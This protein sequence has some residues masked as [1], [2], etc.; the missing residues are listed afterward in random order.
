[1]GRCPSCIWGAII[2]AGV[3]Y[4]SQVVTNYV[5]GKTGSDAW[6][7]VD[8]GK[9]VISAGVG[10]VTGGI[11]GLKAIGTTA[12]VYKAI[13]AS[14]TV[15]MGE[16][17]QQGY[18]NGT[19]KPVNAKKLAIEVTADKLPIPKIKTAK[20]DGAIKV[21]EKVANRAERIGAS[22]VSRAAAIKAAKQEV[23]KLTNQKAA[24]N[25]ANEV[26]SSTAKQVIKEPI[27]NK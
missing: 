19:N 7:N 27:K 6:T 18:E 5:Q 10:A 9:V 13:A 21:A 23:S 3:E 8:M 4:G 22:R 14:A 16:I 11:S 15:G 26:V 24:K 2:G 20:L 1:D 17:V 12:K 25:V